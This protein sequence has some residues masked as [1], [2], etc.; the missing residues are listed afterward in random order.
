LKSKFDRIELL[1][2]TNCLYQ[3]NGKID[4]GIDWS[5]N[6]DIED[7]ILR[8]YFKLTNDMPVAFSLA[9]FHDSKKG[10]CYRQEIMVDIEHLLP[11]KYVIWFE[12]HE[13]DKSGAPRCTDYTETSFRIEIEP[14]KMVGATPE[15]KLYTSIL[16]RWDRGERGAIILPVKITEGDKK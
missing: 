15:D 12:L 4:I 3:Q 5:A 8:I 9:H 14:P 6:E 1:N 13:V 11:G 2:T 7:T 16:N 10:E